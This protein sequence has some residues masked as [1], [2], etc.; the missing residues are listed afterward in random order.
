MPA[1]PRATSYLPHCMDVLESP[2]R[3]GHVGNIMINPGPSERV[4]TLVCSTVGQYCAGSLKDCLGYLSSC[5]GPSGD[6][7]VTLSPE[8][9]D[10]LDNAL[11]RK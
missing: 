11:H 9:L 2:A 4:C 7:E 1:V 3:N 6:G 5:R 8:E 10:G